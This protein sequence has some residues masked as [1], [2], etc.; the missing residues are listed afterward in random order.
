MLSLNHSKHKY[1]IKVANLNICIG[2]ANFRNIYVKYSHSGPI[3]FK[4][5]F[6]LAV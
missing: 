6:H 4:T 3:H 1:F 5:K 2:L